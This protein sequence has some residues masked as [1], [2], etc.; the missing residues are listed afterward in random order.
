MTPEMVDLA[1]QNKTKMG[2]NNIEFE[3][4][5]IESMPVASNS[6]DVVLSNCVLNLVP[7]KNKAFSEI[8]RVLNT[9]KR[10]CVSDIVLKKSLPDSLR[11]PAEFYAGCV[12]GAEMLENYLGIIKYTGF[13]NIKVVKEKPISIPKEILSEYLSTEEINSFG[14]GSD[15]IFSITVYG[16]KP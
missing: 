5:E 4:G 6:I 2:Y 11:K 16:E 8:F 9:G 14:D 10:F 3:L 1:N 7:D 13:V 12:S 15:L